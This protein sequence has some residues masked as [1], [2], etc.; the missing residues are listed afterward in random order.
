MIE[1]QRGG[2]Y[3]AEVKGRKYWYLKEIKSK[4]EIRRKWYL[5]KKSYR[6]IKYKTEDKKM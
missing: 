4:I 6:Q 3:K 5:E 1:G 2:N